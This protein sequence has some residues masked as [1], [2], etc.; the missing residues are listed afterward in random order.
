MFAV[1]RGSLTQGGGNP[2]LGGA[3]GAELSQYSL[4]YIPC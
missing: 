2:G 4:N 3:E 1:C